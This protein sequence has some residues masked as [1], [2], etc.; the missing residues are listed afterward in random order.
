MTRQCAS[1]DAPPSVAQS[2]CPSSTACRSTSTAVL[3][4]PS[5]PQTLEGLTATMSASSINERQPPVALQ[6]IL[7]VEADDG[8]LLPMLQPEIPGNRAVV[9]VHLALPFP[10]VV[11]LAG[12]DVEPPDEPSGAD[13]GL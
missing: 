6:W 12:C 3:L 11:E 7:Q 2:P 9:L 5:T 10:P 4:A 1:V 8:L 13:L